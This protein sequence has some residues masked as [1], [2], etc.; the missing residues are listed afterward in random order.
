MS[1][2]FAQTKD[3]IV[4]AFGD[5]VL[6]R[7]IVNVGYDED[8]YP[9]LELDDGS[10]IWIQCDDENNRPGV[11]VHREIATDTETGLWELH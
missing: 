1:E 2:T 9:V 10:A 11:P 4:T 6:K 8:N 5:K 3:R 7:K